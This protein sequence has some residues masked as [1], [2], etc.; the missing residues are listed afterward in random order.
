[1]KIPK[2]QSKTAEPCKLTTEMS[3]ADASVFQV[4][5]L[6]KPLFSSF[7][8]YPPHGIQHDGKIAAQANPCGD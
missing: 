3:Q 2:S 8:V 7:A 4:Q 1:M 6:R 5:P